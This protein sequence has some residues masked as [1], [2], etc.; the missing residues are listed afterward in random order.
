VKRGLVDLDGVLP[1]SDTH[2]ETHF[3][4]RSSKLTDDV[5]CLKVRAVAGFYLFMPP[6][7]D[8]R[9]SGHVAPHKPTILT[10]TPP[11]V[12]EACF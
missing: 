6:M 10:G 5:D 1:D 12:E 4:I 3:D 7:S 2:H 8:A 9:I 11:K